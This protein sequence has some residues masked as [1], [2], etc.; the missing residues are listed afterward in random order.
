M[1]NTDLVVG[2]FVYRPGG[3]KRRR[4]TGERLERKDIK[5]VGG[6]LR[7]REVQKKRPLVLFSW[8][9]ASFNME[10][11]LGRS[12]MM[13]RASCA[14]L[15]E[16]NHLGLPNIVTANTSRFNDYLLFEGHVDSRPWL[17]LSCAIQ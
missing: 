6:G 11:G 3:R 17:G 13:S 10:V 5:R 12:A 16:L 15:R 1:D 7:H 4:D 8:V 2:E 14:K 9:F